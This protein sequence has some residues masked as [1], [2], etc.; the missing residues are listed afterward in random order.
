MSEG[1]HLRFFLPTTI[2]SLLTQ[3][4]IPGIRKKLQQKLYKFFFHLFVAPKIS[5]KIFL[6]Y[7]SSDQLQLKLICKIFNNI[8]DLRYPNIIL[9][10]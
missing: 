4:R 3:N 10:S 7:L 5:L 1:K 9:I 8:V 6:Q 2:M